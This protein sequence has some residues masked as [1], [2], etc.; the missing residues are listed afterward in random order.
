MFANHEA[1]DEKRISSSTSLPEL[2]R[3]LSLPMLQQVMDANLTEEEFWLRA[4]CRPEL[5]NIKV[6]MLLV[7]AEDDPVVPMEAFPTKELV[8]KNPMLMSVVTKYVVELDSV[9]LIRRHLLT[10]RIIITI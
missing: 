4:D 5:V 8:M 1:F 6:P 7:H 10:L 9:P 2:Q 3:C